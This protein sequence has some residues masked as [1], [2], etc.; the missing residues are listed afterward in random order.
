MKTVVVT[1]ANR[2]LGLELA[3][4]YID[5]AFEGIGDDGEPRWR[6]IAVARKHTDVTHG[7]AHVRTR[8]IDVSEPDASNALG[9]VLEQYAPVDVLINN[10]AVCIG[11]E[12]AVGNVDY[13]AW[14]R[15]FETN[16]MGAM[17]VLEAALPHLARDAVVVNV[18]GRMGSI[19]RVMA[20]LGASS[21]TT[22]DVVYR[23]TKAALNMMTVCAASEFK[24]KDETRDVKVVAVDPGWMNTDMG[25]RG[26]TVTAPLDPSES[27]A[28]IV[29]LIA[30]LKPEDSGKFLNWR[31]E[32][33]PW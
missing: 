24:A 20:G 27:A 26:G 23:T 12:C 18:S 10:A 11:R 32:E 7:H 3:R 13:G 21:A 31:G 5:D 33:S 29:A 14:T 16:V 22:Q 17:R 30:G 2:G 4:A 8:G 19:G 9:I 6:V 1:G 25:S 15:S 28:G